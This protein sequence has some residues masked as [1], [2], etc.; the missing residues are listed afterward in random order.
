M[1]LVLTTGNVSSPCT[2]TLHKPLIG[3]GDAN[4]KVKF[5]TTVKSTLTQ[6]WKFLEYPKRC[7]AYIKV[8]ENLRKI[9]VPDTQKKLLAIKV[10]RAC[11]VFT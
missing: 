3:T 6:L 5:I 7:S 1:V 4:D 2:N 11:V 10:Q 9:Q 8:C